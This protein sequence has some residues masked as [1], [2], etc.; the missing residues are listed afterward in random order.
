MSQ[1]AAALDQDR[2][3]A[4]WSR[5][6]ATRDGLEVFQQLDAA[7]TEPIRFYH[8]AAHITDCLVQLDWSRNLAIRPDEVEAA[9]WFHDAVYDPAATDNEERSG[10]LAA[11]ALSRAG[12]A[13]GVPERVEALVE[14]TK[15]HDPSGSDAE[16]LCDIDLSILG[17]D[18]PEFEQFE[19]LIRQEY[20]WLPEADYRRGR[21]EIVSGFLRRSSIYRTDQ[22][23]R[24]YERT[25]RR[26]LEWLLNLL[27]R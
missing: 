24:R 17:R 25:A 23:A 7:Y 4:L 21:S 20:A 18:R 6:G 12:V 1:E 10:R 15:R 22:F 5:L 27:S 26:N 3:L 9:I 19:R 11:S 13:A 16:L 8:T 14:V 2:W